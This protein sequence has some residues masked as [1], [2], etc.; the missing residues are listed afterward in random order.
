MARFGEADRSQITDQLTERQRT[1]KDPVRLP[2]VPP[3]AQDTYR[4]GQVFYDDLS[5]PIGPTTRLTM[6]E[7]AGGGRRKPPYDTAVGTSGGGEIV[8][9]GRPS[10]EL[11]SL[12]VMEGIDQ[13]LRVERLIGD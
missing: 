3:E 6:P 9:P 13:L 1:G 8:P 7:A 2:I 10:E 5:H 4:T 11:P 12:G